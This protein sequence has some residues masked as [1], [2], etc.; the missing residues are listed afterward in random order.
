PAYAT[1]IRLLT[2]VGSLVFNKVG[3][4]NE[5]FPTFITFKGFFS[6]VNS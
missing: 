5:S 6:C 4:L 2:C 1:S 3:V